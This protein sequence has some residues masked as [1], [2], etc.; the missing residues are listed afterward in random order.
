MNKKIFDLLED[1][2]WRYE[3]YEDFISY[4]PV[5][6][7]ILDKHYNS[8]DSGETINSQDIDYD[9]INVIGFAVDLI[10]VLDKESE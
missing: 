4:L 3:D 2:G 9:L 6:K 7:S 10:S 1:I 5:Y 8:L